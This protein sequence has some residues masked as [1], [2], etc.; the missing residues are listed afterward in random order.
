MPLCIKNANCR[1]YADDTLLGMDI[2][3]CGQDAL[4]SNV[5]QLCDWS[6]KWGMN[7]NPSKCMHMEV[8]RNLPNFKLFMNGVAIPQ[9]SNLKY[10]GVF[11]QSDLKWH[12]HIQSIVNKSNKTLFMMIRCLFNTSFKTKMIAFNTVVRPVLEYASQVWSPHTKALIDQIE[13]IQRRAVRWIFRLE[14]LDSVSE[15]M[16][17]NSVEK[18]E[19]RRQDLDLTFLKKIEFGL[20]D[21][22][23][24]S[25]INFNQAYLTRHGAIN[26]H[27]GTDQYK[28]S[29]FNRML[30]LVSKIGLDD[31]FIVSS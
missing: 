7:F 9:T 27:F 26:P 17:A 6:T 29:F 11:I 13:R 10:L 22:D 2:T 18:L 25:Y 3:D 19:K 14:K 1:L 15:C 12:H 28:F 5:T 16:E 4:Q 31:N 23:L 30:P 20:Y 24:N 21:L 8:G